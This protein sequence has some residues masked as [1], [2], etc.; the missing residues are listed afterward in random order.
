MAHFLPLAL[1]RFRLAG[2]QGVS[3]QRPVVGIDP[4]TDEDWRG[5]VRLRRGNDWEGGVGLGRVWDNAR[6]FRA[7][8]G[9]E[10]RCLYVVFGSLKVENGCSKDR[11]VIPHLHRVLDTG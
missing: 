2:P 6:S 5:G 8:L 3:H 10:V 9:R 11:V 1:G 7:G 4:R